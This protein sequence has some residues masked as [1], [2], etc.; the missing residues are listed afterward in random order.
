[1]GLLGQRY[2]LRLNAPTSGLTLR[3]SSLKAAETLER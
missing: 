2:A 3:M 1:M